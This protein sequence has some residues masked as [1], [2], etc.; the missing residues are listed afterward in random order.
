MA[1]KIRFHSFPRTSPPPDFASELV[2]VF[3]AHESEIGSLHLTKGL[4][5]DQVLAI[6]APDLIDLGFLVEQG[7][8]AE[9]KIHRPVFFGEDGHPTLK[10]EV[11]AYQPSWRCGLE[12]EAGR[13][14]MGNA[15][16]RDLVQ[17][18]V[19]VEVDTLALAVSNVYRYRT[20]GRVASSMDYENTQRV[21]ETLFA[22]SRVRLPYRLILIGY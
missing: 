9:Q 20:G 12:V 2:G 11:D 16:Y 10:Y 3:K 13:A 22:H 15:V 7:K 1:T 18:M 6:L 8:K 4:T 17:A 5:S 14:W 21:A 19:M